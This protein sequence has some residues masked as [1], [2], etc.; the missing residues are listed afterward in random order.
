MKNE[1]YEGIDIPLTDTMRTDI[2][3]M[4]LDLMDNW[5]RLNRFK[6]DDLYIRSH[7]EALNLFIEGRRNTN[8]WNPGMGYRLGDARFIYM[9]E[10]GLAAYFDY[11]LYEMTGD[12]VWR[13]RAFQQMYF[14]LKAQNTDPE[15]PNFGYVQTTYSLAEGYGPSGIG[16]NSDDRGTNIGWKPG[17]NAHIVRYMLRMWELVKERE[18]IDRQDWY[19]SAINSMNWVVRQQN[20]DGGLPQDIEPTD[21]QYQRDADWM[22]TN[23]PVRVLP[24]MG[25]R[26]PSAA[27]GRAL[28][29]ITVINKIVDDPRYKQLM[30]GMEAFALNHV[31]NDYWFTGHHPDLPPQ[32]F[33]E[34]S[35]WGVC[36]FWLNRYDDTGDP[37]YLKHAEANV[38]LALTWMCPKQLSWVD[39]PTQFCSAEQEHYFTYTLYCYQN[40]KIE[41]LQR[42]YDLTSRQLY[43]EM[44][45]RILQG[46][47]FTQTTGKD[48]RLGGTYERTS[49]PWL[50]RPIRDGKPD[51]NSLG[52]HYMNEQSLDTFLQT[53]LLYRQGND[54]YMGPGLDNKLFP[55]GTCYYNRDISR[56]SRVDLAVIPSEGIIHVQITAWNTGHMNWTVQE[57]EGQQ[58]LTHVVSGLQPD[59]RYA[60]M[61]NGQLYKT[62]KA[63]ADGKVNFEYSGEFTDA[64]AFMVEEQH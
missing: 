30:T 56:E 6:A 40:R 25:K 34:A 13:A 1:T 28:P 35:I 64:Q 44:R 41:C 16:F 36:E 14:I 29:A 11:L 63:G 7:D 26:S 24:A 15:H 19:E 39:N 33:E 20:W 4:I 52:P 45:E 32:D 53:L 2:E 8:Y 51:F 23:Q 57:G 27:S 55:D 61:I 54:L 47:Y 10:Q 3:S 22:G 46:I 50:A 60:V 48:D 12:P 5:M 42:L 43:D 62:Y 18:G 37:A 59:T 31:Q 21:L 58:T 49:D 17:I 9:G 38:A